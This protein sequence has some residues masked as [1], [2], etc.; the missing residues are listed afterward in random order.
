MDK[1][2]FSDESSFTVRLKKLRK[3]VWRKQGKY[4][5]V[6]N[7]VPT[8]KSGYVAISVWAVFSR[9]G[10]T[11]LVLI[12]GTLKQGQYKKILLEEVVQ[13]ASKFYGG[14]K[15]IVFQQD[16]CGPHK[17]KSMKAFLVANDV[18]M[19]Y[20]TAQSPDLNPIENAWAMLKRR[21]RKRANYPKNADDLFDII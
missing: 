17:A 9:L 3:R 20:Q 4:F 6:Q 13:L 18:W 1:V 12:E 11:P 7:I 2:L 10:S 15:N 8:F 21:L 14:P 19:M 5:D 16:N